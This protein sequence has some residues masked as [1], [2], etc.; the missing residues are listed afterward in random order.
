MLAPCDDILTYF[1]GSKF[2]WWDA[3]HQYWKFHYYAINHNHVHL[4]KSLLFLST[5][6]FPWVTHCV[7]EYW[8]NGWKWFM[9]IATTS[10]LDPTYGWKHVWCCGYLEIGAWSKFESWFVLMEFQF[11]KWA[12]IDDLFRVQWCK[13][14]YLSPFVGLMSLLW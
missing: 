5:S 13:W 10:N 9:E 14:W 6:L 7:D 8:I 12:C 3:I 4:W 2:V 11:H 1:F